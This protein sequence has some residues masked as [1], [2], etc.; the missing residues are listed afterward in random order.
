M[1]N[2]KCS[3][4][5]YI[6]KCVN[7]AGAVFDNEKGVARY[8]VSHILSRLIEL[9]RMRDENPRLAEDRAAF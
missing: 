1:K 7:L 4:P 3:V 2:G 6:Q 5:A 9:E 8:F